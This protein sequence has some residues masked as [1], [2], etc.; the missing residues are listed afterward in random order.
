[1]KEAKDYI[2]D[3]G[4][5]RKTITS[6]AHCLTVEG[7]NHIT[8]SIVRDAIETS[9]D[10][11][12]NQAFD[13]TT[14]DEA[15]EY[16]NAYELC[17][18]PYWGADELSKAIANSGRDEK[19]ALRAVTLAQKVGEI[20]DVFTPKQG[21][22]WAMDRGYLIGYYAGFVGTK[23]GTYGH[24]HNPLSDGPHYK[25]STLVTQT[26][27]A[28]RRL[29]RLREL[30]GRSTFKNS[31]WTFKGIAVLVKSEKV[32]QRK[33]SDEKTI[34]ADLKEAAQSERETKRAGFADGL[35]Q[36]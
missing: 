16:L 31:E 36:R 20:P 25:Q 32:E 28:E 35:G 17:Y 3:D 13:S 5:G 34:R 7:L 21:I 33:R 6:L 11:E 30:G 10:E 22:E 24:P 15:R 12:F 27:D 26:P 1:M 9:T 2:T 8:A 19:L 18:M 14:K 29:S 4:T 23:R